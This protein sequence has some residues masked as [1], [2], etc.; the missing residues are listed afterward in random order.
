MSISAIAKG[1]TI[2]LAA[3]AITYTIS[4]ASG[5]QMKK[6][7]NSAGKAI[8]AIGDVVDGISYMLH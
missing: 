4:N 2:G 3:G 1:I 6:V 5:K 8:R 7:K